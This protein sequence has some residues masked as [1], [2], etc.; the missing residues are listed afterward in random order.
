MK[1]RKIIQLNEL[2]RD[3]KTRNLLLKTKFIIVKITNG[4]IMIVE[5]RM[6]HQHS[7]CIRMFWNYTYVKETSF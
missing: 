3:N 4:P 5:L 6:I 1:K 2:D 7:C